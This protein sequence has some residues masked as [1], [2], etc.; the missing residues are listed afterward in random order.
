MCRFSK[1][2]RDGARKFV[3]MAQASTGDGDYITCPCAKCRNLRSQHVDIVYEHLVITG[4]NPNYAT[5]VLHG[6]SPSVHLQHTDLEISDAYKMYRDT[7]DEHDED[8]DQSSDAYEQPNDHERVSYKRKEDVFIQ[9]DVVEAPL[10]PGCTKYTRLSVATILLKHKVDN[11]LSNKSFTELLQ[12][13]KDILPL[14]NTIP[15]SMYSIK[16][17]LKE[18]D[19]GYEKI[20]ACI[21][22]CCLFRKEKKDMDTCPKCG[23][24]RWKVN[25]RTNKI[26]K[27]IPVKVLSYFPIIPRFRRMFKSEIMA[28]QLLWHAKN[29]SQDGKMRHS[30]DSPAWKTIDRKWPKFAADPRNLRLGLTTD[31][32][33]PFR[34]L[35]SR[36]SC[37]PVILVTYNLPPWLCMLQENIMLTLLIPGPKQPGNDIDVYLEPLIEELNE[38]WNNGVNMYDKIHV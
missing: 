15:D 9:K 34:D 6:E 23:A 37:W 17:L 2:Y 26:K 13:L 16:K 11:G 12:I 4:M 5:W 7:Y 21:N 36:Y 35:S 14:E 1:Q 27:G 10:Y 19:L 30:V 3:S 32:F 20:D 28:E 31:G 8:T 33:N 18:F 25:Q 38:L 24:S 22:D 29:Q